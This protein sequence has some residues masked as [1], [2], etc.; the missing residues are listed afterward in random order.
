MSLTDEEYKAQLER[1]RKTKAEV[2]RIIKPETI[3]R[4]RESYQKIKWEFS[5]GLHLLDSATPEQNWFSDETVDSFYA[6]ILERIK[7][8]AKELPKLRQ[9][10]RKAEKAREKYINIKKSREGEKK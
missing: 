8:L 10:Y 5:T 9:A 3:K 2:M 6:S 4:L 1:C 7:L